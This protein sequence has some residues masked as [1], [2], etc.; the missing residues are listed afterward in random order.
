[1]MFSRNL[2]M[3][4]GLTALIVMGGAAIAAPIIYPGN[5]LFSVGGPIQPPGGEYIL[6]TDHTGRDI[7]AMMVWGTR[8]SLLFAFGAAGISLLFGVVFGAVSGYFGGVVDDVMSRFFEMFDVIPRMFLIILI[9]AIFGSHLWLTVMIVGLTMWPSNARL[10]RAQVLTLKKRGYAQ[11]ALVSGGSHMSILFG[12]IVPNGIGPV[13]ANSTLQMAYAVLTEAGLSF[14]GLSD[15][16]VASW[17]QI[18]YWG[19]GFISSAPWMVIFPGLA[20]AALL[21]SFHLIGS[22]LQQQLNPRLQKALV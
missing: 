11:A 8:V 21:L 3:V 18:L 15:P 7:A 20:I 14:L 13:T 9:V 6:G 12:H 17:G 1:M 2:P 16:N 5:P 19:Q 22:H 4:F 10:M